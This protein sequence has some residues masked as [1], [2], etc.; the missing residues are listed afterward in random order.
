MGAKLQAAITQTNNGQIAPLMEGRTD[1]QV[2]P[3]SCREAKNTIPL[4]YGASKN[5]GGTAFVHTTTDGKK[6]VLVEFKVGE[7]VAYM[8][9]FGDNYI[10]VLKDHEVV[11]DMSFAG[12]GYAIEDLIDNKGFC[13][14]DFQQS[15][16][17]LYLVHDK[18]PPRKLMRYSDTNWVLAD[19]DIKGGPWQTMNTDENKRIKAS[20]DNGIVDLTTGSGDN[21]EC[22]FVNVRCALSSLV[23]GLTYVKMYVRID[24]TQVAYKEFRIVSSTGSFAEEAASLINST[25]SDLQ[26]TNP[27]RANLKLIAVNNQNNYKNKD[28]YIV[29]DVTDMSGTYH[30]YTNSTTFSDEYT[31]VDVFTED[32]VGLSVRLTQVD[33]SVPVWFAG[34]NIASIGTIVK[35]DGHYYS[36]AS[37]GTCGSVKPTHTEGTEND[38]GVTWTYLHDG[39]GWGVITEYIS[40]TQAKMRVYGLLPAGVVSVGTYKWELSLFGQNGIWPSSVCFFNDRLTFGLNAKNGPIVCCSCTGDY[41]NFSDMTGG[42]VLATNAITLP[43]LLDL[44]KIQW[45]C[46]QDNLFVGTEGGIV[47]VKAMTSSEVF[48]PDNITY[49]NISSIGTCKIKPIRIGDDILYLGRLAKDIYAIQYNWETDSYAPDEVSLLAYNLLEE[50]VCS[51]ALQYEPNRIVWLVRKD[52]KM[53]GLTYNK[54]QSVRAFHLHETDGNF[55]SVAC[56]PASDGTRDELY[57]VV[58]R[59]IGNTLVR[60]V[61]TFKNGLPLDVESGLTKAEQLEYLIKNCWFLDCAKNYSFDEATDTITGLDHLEGKSVAVLADGKVQTSK[62][63]SSGSITLDSAANIVLVGLSYEMKLEP[64]PLNIDFN[65]T[66]QA[67]SQRINQM[68]CRLYRSAN[69]KYSWDGVNWHE[70]EVKGDNEL[71]LK[72]GDLIL[73]WGDSNTFSKLN[74]DD[75]VNATGA[76]MIFK[77]D[78]PLPVC[79]VAFY[80]QIE[81]SNG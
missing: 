1:V 68:I 37:T 62:I 18:Y 69:F 36:S 4:V 43:I 75:I 17:V 7:N 80:P 45:L 10:K 42:E 31:E 71:T 16:D 66:G 20:A 21:P 40:P 13:Q 28:I 54:K 29:I 51:W 67:R 65:G 33:T 74:S 23:V 63:V 6:V 49:D 60:Y 3:Y 56:I 81:V 32:M 39:N 73:N 27:S 47:A 8:L 58:K 2:F 64:M 38:G 41:E 70:A 19:L 53:V 9:E 55:E 61:E 76:R 24:N 22:L 34:K 78:T 57:A 44:N 11:Y 14:L 25:L 72:S 15:G 26:A 77:Q 5:R 12:A 30:S 59:N 35:S 79:F 52:G 46:A 48:G 50:G